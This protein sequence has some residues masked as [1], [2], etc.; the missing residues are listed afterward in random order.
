MTK[1]LYGS[2][3][4]VAGGVHLAI[5]EAVRLQMDAVQIFTKNQRQWSSPPLATEQ[6]DLWRAAV[7]STNWNDASQRI[8][9]HNSYLGR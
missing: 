6:V 4:S 9:S 1:P 3:L 7:R 2:H 8:V 5:E